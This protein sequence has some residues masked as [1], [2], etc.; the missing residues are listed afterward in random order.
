VPFRRILET[1]GA[2]LKIAPSVCLSTLTVNLG[3]IKIYV[4]IEISY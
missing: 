4:I 2:Y 1:N 3:I